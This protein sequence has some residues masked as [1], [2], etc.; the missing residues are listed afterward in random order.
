MPTVFFGRNMRQHTAIVVALL[1]ISAMT[2]G[3]VVTV[4]AETPTPETATPGTATPGTGTATATPTDSPTPQTT[5]PGETP[6]TS[7]PADSPTPATPGDT[8]T[9]GGTATPPSLPTDTPTPQ[10]TATPTPD[11]GADD[12]RPASFVET[13]PLDENQT[14]PDTLAGKLRVEREH[15][16]NTTVNLTRN[17]ASNYTMEITVTGDATNVTFFLQQQAVA[18]SQNISNV[19]MY[20]DGEEHEYTV[21]TDAGPGNSP[22]IRFVVPHFSTR[23]VSF[24]SAS[25]DS[26][27]AVTANSKTP[28]DLDGDGTFEDVDGN[29]KVDIFDVQLLFT[30][31]NAPAVQNNPDAFNFDGTGGVDIFDVQNLFNAI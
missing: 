20:L 28:Q 7:T 8:D 6:A 12:D 2:V 1:T 3:A 25:I 24:E 21:D 5:T 11:D 4:T 13:K 14:N 15:H 16:A 18:S 9:P 29:G 19:T 26:P 31:Q 22:W 17:T 23:Q 27:P 30:N 10:A